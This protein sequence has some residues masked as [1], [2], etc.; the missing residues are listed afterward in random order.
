[1]T[2]VSDLLHRYAWA[3]DHRELDRF[4]EV[5][6][7]EATM[8]FGPGGVREGREAIRA[9]IREALARYDV[10]QHYIS[11]IT[12]G[13]GEASCY[14]LAWHLK[15]DKPPFIVGG[16]YRDRLVA[17]GDGPRIAH[18]TLDWRWQR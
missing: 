15:G 6:T 17:T 18:R 14:F 13:E 11:N 3:I 12:E 16:E 2:E 5:F 4:D 10:V 1:V 8:D 7:P 9:F